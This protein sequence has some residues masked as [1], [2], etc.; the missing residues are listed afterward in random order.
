MKGNFWRKI[1]RK[2]YNAQG[3]HSA[4]YNGTMAKTDWHTN[5]SKLKRYLDMIFKEL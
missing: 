4:Q 1:F 2:G 3:Y 5:R